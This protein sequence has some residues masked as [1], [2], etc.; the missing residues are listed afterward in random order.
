MENCIFCKI[1]RG[2]IPSWKVYEDEHT[3]AFLDINP[4]ARYHTIV[5]PKT[6]HENIFD[7][8]PA[9]FSHVCTT[10][11]H[12]ADLYQEK[13]GLTDLQIRHNAGANAQQ[14]VFHLHMHIVPRSADD[15]IDILHIP[16]PE[17]RETFDDLLKKLL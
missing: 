7:I 10:V 8:P 9:V 1:I 5:I 16:H 13:L 3:L 4:V 6:H 12:L 17:W 15:G 11:K 14:D 2:E